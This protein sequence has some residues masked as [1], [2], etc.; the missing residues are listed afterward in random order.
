MS[1]KKVPGVGKLIRSGKSP[2][3]A[4]AIAQRKAEKPPKKPPKKFW[5]RISGLLH[6][7]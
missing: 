3:Q 7:R 5:G 2:K 1:R 4:E 6:S